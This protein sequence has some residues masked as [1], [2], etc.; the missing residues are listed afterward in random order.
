MLVTSANVN[1]LLRIPEVTQ[2]TLPKLQSVVNAQRDAAKL[3][4]FQPEHGGASVTFTLPFPLQ[5]YVGAEG[6]GG[7]CA[8]GIT[9]EAAR[10]SSGVKCVCHTV[11]SEWFRTVP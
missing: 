7:H 9:S 1:L 10:D 6:F 11:P 4:A 2:K 3:A 8:L 5:D